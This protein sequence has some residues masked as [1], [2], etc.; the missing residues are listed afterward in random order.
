MWQGAP[1]VFIMLSAAGA[2]ECL[3]SRAATL[4]R[5]LAK[6]HLGASL[7]SW[8]R[9]MNAAVAGIHDAV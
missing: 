8:P 1:D 3:Q 2:K 6:S 9:F 7:I 4:E 5:P